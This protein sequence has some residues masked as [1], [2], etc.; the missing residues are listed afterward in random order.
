MDSMKKYLKGIITLH[1]LIFNLYSDSYGDE[2]WVK[3]V[4]MGYLSQENMARAITI[5][6]NYGK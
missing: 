4:L 2:A 3:D 1:E 5:I 6:N